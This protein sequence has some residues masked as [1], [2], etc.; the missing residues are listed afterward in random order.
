MPFLEKNTT[1]IGGQA[2]RGNGPMVF[3]Y[4]TEDALTAVAAA[5][6][7]NTYWDKLLP[8]D[9]WLVSVVDFADDSSFPGGADNEGKPGAST[10]FGMFLVTAVNEAAK[11]VTVTKITLS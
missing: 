7:F 11:T 5:G 10:A 3:A 4:N 6:Y 9:I 8:G 1:N 2:R